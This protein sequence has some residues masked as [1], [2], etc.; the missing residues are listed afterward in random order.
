[1]F[2]KP[3]KV[4]I[5]V[6]LLSLPGGV[7]GL[8]NLLKLNQFENIEYFSVNFNS[9]K[10]GV[11][12]LPIRY[13]VFLIKLTKVNIVHINPSMDAKSFYRDLVFCFISKVIF[14]KKTIIYWH[15]WQ[16]DFFNKIKNSKLNLFLLKNSFNK[17]DIQLVL[18]TRF[19]DD[20]ISI[21]YKG[22]VHLESNVTEKINVTKTFNKQ[23]DEIW[24]LLFISRITKGK[25]W[26]IAIKTLE[27]INKLKNNN[28][29]LTIAGDGDCLNEAKLLKEKHEIS[30]INFTGH[31]S[32]EEK[33]N[34]LK[35][36]DIL[37]FPTCYPEGMPITILEGMMYGMPIISRNE[38]GI[39][40]HVNNNI[41]GFLTD[42]VDP[43]VFADL[44]LNLISDSLLFK[45]ISENNLKTAN[46][47]F[48]PE[49]LTNKLLE[50]YN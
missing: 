19:K 2:K 24:N 14:R 44:I 5:T 33:V 22:V 9:K 26:D 41:N 49:R 47:K 3:K 7:T 4:L 46:I 37:F 13:F 10:W 34:L 32:G 21:G 29:K 48:I 30:N 31:I 20:L 27:I 16:N 43:K 35:Q 12:F 25:G 50:L 40:D 23:K 8:Y 15:G 45:Q 38:G 39:P 42:S 1:M 28:V 11:L 18:S 17:S 36:S 6:P